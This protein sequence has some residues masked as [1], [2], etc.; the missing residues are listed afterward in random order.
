MSDLYI[1]V[2]S[3][4]ASTGW[5]RPTE[6]IT[7]PTIVD[8]VVY[9]LVLVF[10]DGQNEIR[11]EAP[12]NRV[13]WDFENDGTTVTSNGF[14]QTYTYDY[15][16][17]GGDVNVYEYNGLNRNYKQVIF[18]AEQVASL[19]TETIWELQNNMF[20][21]IRC[22]FAGLRP[23]VNLSSNPYLKII[24]C[25][26][27]GATPTRCWNNLSYLNLEQ[28]IVPSPVYFFGNQQQ[29]SVNYDLGEVTGEVTFTA[30]RFKK[31][32]STNCKFSTSNALEIDDITIGT[33]GLDR[34]F[35][36]TFEVT[37]NIDCA[38]TNVRRLFAQ[39]TSKKLIFSSFPANPTSMN[40][41]N[42]LRP[43]YNCFFLEELVLPGCESGFS[44][45][46]CRMG[47]TA[48]DALFTSLGTASGTQTITITG[49]PGASTCDTTI[50]TGKGYT[51]V[52]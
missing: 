43:F 19:T 34:F 38:G 32:D 6:W 27:Q 22:S 15:A 44:I 24:E 4:G 49:N 31:I 8:K 3:A 5:T 12:F 40:L 9:G 20:A 16:S 21:D 50:A 29:L 23:R 13:E 25:T 51:V 41:T 10:E 36:S 18:K 45:I 26:N 17:L 30:S 2:K 28:F 33:N 42:T 46:N 1:K 14:P 47:A 11:V 52:T 35:G 37:G 39:S 7:M 48:L